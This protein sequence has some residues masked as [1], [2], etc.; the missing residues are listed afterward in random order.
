MYQVCAA[1]KQYK[2]RPIQQKKLRTAQEVKE[3]VARFNK[4]H[5]DYE[6]YKDG[7]LWAVGDEWFGCYTVKDRKKVN[8]G[9]D[10]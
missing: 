6:I 7:V 10:K 3:A 5:R 1:N 9:L 2:D 8:V 4:A